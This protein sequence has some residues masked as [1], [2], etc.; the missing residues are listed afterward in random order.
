MESPAGHLHNQAPWPGYTPQP[1]GRP[2]SC[3]CRRVWWQ[4]IVGNWYPGLGRCYTSA[5]AV[6]AQSHWCSSPCSQRPVTYMQTAKPLSDVWARLQGWW[7]YVVAFNFAKQTFLTWIFLTFGKV[8]KFLDNQKTWAI[9]VKLIGFQNIVGPQISPLL[10]VVHYNIHEENKNWLPA[11]ATVMWTLHI[12][13]MSAWVFC[14]CSSFLPHPKICTWGERECLSCPRM[15]EGGWVVV[16]SGPVMD[17][18]PVPGGSCGHLPP[19][20]DKRVGKELP[21]LLLSTLLKCLYNSHL[22]QS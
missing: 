13:S 4:P 1:H 11:G 22:F 20:L 15:S 16:V 7:G 10:K 8:F 5:L 2:T 18:H 21:Y 6:S 17:G 9:L 3:G 14:G 12:F 19:W